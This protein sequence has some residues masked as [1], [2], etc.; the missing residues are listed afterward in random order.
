MTQDLG[1]QRDPAAPVATLRV[2]E[3]AGDGTRAL[4]LAPSYPWRPGRTLAKGLSPGA[5]LALQRSAGNAAVTRALSRSPAAA[6]TTSIARCACGGQ[7]GA[8][9]LCDRCRR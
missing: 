7:I 9:G 3:R 4:G 5:V 6:A 2:D 8:D 1:D